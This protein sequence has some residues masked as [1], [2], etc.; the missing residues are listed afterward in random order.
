PGLLELPPG[1]LFELVVA[2]APAADVAGAAASA[3]VEGLGVVQGGSPGRL[4]AG[5]EPAGRVAGGDV[6]PEPGGGPVGPR[7]ALVGAS[8]GRLVRFGLCQR[9][10]QRPGRCPGPG[11]GGPARP[12][13][14]TRAAGV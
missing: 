7:L 6:V 5:R 11:G 1:M 2:P 14:P 13:P 3:V 8:A 9:L 12:A 10:S 4:A